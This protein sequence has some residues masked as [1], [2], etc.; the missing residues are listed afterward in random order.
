MTLVDTSQH[1]ANVAESADGH[2]NYQPG[3]CNHTHQKNN[4]PEYFPE[5]HFRI[6]LSAS[7]DT[8]ARSGNK[9]DPAII[10]TTHAATAVSPTRSAVSFSL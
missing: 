9:S 4:L 10:A 8:S 3:E 1:R 2:D 5:T 7:L 6:A